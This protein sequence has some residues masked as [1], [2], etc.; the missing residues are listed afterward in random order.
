MIALDANV[1]IY[2]HRPDLPQHSI[3]ASILADRTSPLGIPDSVL[4]TFV[5]ITTNPRIFKVPSTHEQAFGFC[6]VLRSRPD[7][8]V[9]AS[10]PDHWQIFRRLCA[11]VDARGDLV[12]DTWLAALAI[13]HDCEWI[14]FDQDFALFPELRWRNPAA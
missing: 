7:V 3:S 8:T 12:T 14:S 1:L 5:R 13:E 11:R 4:G 6:D 9:L 2:A 10:G